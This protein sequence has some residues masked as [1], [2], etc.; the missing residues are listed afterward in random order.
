MAL[1]LAKGEPRAFEP[2][3]GL[4][5]E[6]PSHGAVNMDG[7]V[8]D[9][10][11]DVETAPGG[12]LEREGVSELGDP[13]TRS[14]VDIVVCGAGIKKGRER[15]GVEVFGRNEGGD[16]GIAMDG[17]DIEASTTDRE[18]VFV[19]SALDKRDAVAD[20]DEL[21]TDGANE[22]ALIEREEPE[23]ILKARNVR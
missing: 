6:S 19:G 11:P 16:A 18:P 8:A 12:R 23:R 22:S 13:R 14:V 10:G 3:E 7:P 1:G 17:D 21:G 5:L 9:P 2:G 20:G 4:G 15:K